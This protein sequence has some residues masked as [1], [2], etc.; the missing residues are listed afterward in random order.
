MACIFTARCCVLV[1]YGATQVWRA[2]KLTVPTLKFKNQEIWE[3]EV[4]LTELYE[5]VKRKP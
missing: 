2:V 5:C 4:L 1:N 3:P